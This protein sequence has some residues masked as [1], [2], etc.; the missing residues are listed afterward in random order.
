MKK[1]KRIIQLVISLCFLV[2]IS[3]AQQNDSVKEVQNLSSIGINQQLNISYDLS[4]RIVVEAQRIGKSLGKELTIAIVDRSAI[5]VLVVRCDKHS[6]LHYEFALYKAKT[7]AYLKKPTKK[8]EGESLRVLNFDKTNTLNGIEGGVPIFFQ[9]EFIGAIG[10][11]G[12]PQ[13]IDKEIAETALKII[14]QPL[15]GNAEIRKNILYVEDEKCKEVALFYHEMIG[16]PY[17][18]E[19]TDDYSWVEFKTGNTKLCIHHNNKGMKMP[20]S[21]SNH[22]VFYMDNQ[23]QVNSL[24]QKLIDSNYKKKKIGKTD[25]VL[26]LNEISQ[27]IHWKNKNTKAGNISSFWVSDP[28]GNI[29]QIEPKHEE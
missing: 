26:K 28:V 17:N 15:T 5:P 18:N 19:I 8:I 10:I 21:G 29:V 3:F 27:M 22:I 11:T 6:E 23:K 9:G 1:Q 4:Q 24:Y 16:I 7:A 25:K 14:D 2:S 13:E 20:K 12:A